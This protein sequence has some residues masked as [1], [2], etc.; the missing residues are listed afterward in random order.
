[1]SKSTI[2]PHT[3]AQLTATEEASSTLLHRLHTNERQLRTLAVIL[4]LTGGLALSFALGVGI[5]IYWYSHKCKQK[6]QQQK[7]YPPS[8]HNSI[9]VYQEPSEQ[10]SHHHHHHH[11]EREL[12]EASIPSEPGPSSNEP[13]IPQFLIPPPISTVQTPEPSAPTAKELHMCDDCMAPPP[14]YSED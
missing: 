3:I 11:H 4:S 14:A 8:E 13:M 2:I 10:H 1:M 5:L 7:S 12:E 6:R 9:V